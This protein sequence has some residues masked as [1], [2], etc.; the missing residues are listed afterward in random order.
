M[1]NVTSERVAQVLAHV[2]TALPI[3]VAPG[4]ACEHCAAHDDAARQSWAYW[5]PA[6]GEVQGLAELGAT[7]AWV[8]AAPVTEGVTWQSSRTMYCWDGTGENP[9]RPVALCPACAADHHERWDDM[10]SNVYA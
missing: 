7:V 1:S 4:T 9:N 8:P 6:E 3:P 5:H 2:R 10:W